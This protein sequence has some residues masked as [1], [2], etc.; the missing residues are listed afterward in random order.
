MQISGKIFD[1][2]KR[3]MIPSPAAGKRKDPP[4]CLETRGSF[5]CRAASQPKGIK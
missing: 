1:Y 2:R 3:D 4:V 5:K